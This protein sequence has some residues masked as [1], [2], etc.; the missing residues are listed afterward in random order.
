MAK[1]R[2]NILEKARKE[3]LATPSAGMKVPDGYFASFAENMAAMLP[4]R[5]ELS[6]APVAGAPRTK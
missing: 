4:E 2:E 6:Q 1:D 5:P 3:G